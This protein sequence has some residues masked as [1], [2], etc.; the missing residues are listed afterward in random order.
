[1]KTLALFIGSLISIGSWG[2]PDSQI[3]LYGNVFGNE[4]DVLLHDGTP[5]LDALSGVQVL[6][7]SDGI[8]FHDQSSQTNGKYAAVLDA[9]K[10]YLV[11]FKKHGYLTRSFTVDALGLASQ[12]KTEVVRLYAD[13]TLFTT[14]NILAE[15]TFEDEP[16]AHAAYHSNHGRMEFD[17]DFRRGAFE[18]FLIAVKSNAALAREE[19]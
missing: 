2:S 9:G 10:Q 1:M 15:S 3:L 6:I 19:R 13:V 17:S 18:A 5:S 4:I 8:T 12:T 16:F 7:T 11:T 14:N